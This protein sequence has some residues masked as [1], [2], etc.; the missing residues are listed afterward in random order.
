MTNRKE[1]LAQAEL[2]HERLTQRLERA[3]TNGQRFPPRGR[4]TTAYAALQGH[5]QR[6]EILEDASRR[7]LERRQVGSK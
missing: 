6:L 2:T 3:V 4:R 7:R 5:I 1:L